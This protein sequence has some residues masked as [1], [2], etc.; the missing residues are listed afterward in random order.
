MVMRET[1]QAIDEAAAEWATR[2]EAAHLP[3]EVQTELDL[4]L[5]GD[6]RR[7]GAFARARAVIAQVRRAKALGP[8]VLSGQLE[9]DAVPAL[10]AA[11]LGTGLRRRQLLI[12]GS[13]AVAASIA[14]AWM[15]SGG[16]SLN[17]ATARG[18]VRLIPLSDGSSVTLNTLSRIAVSFD[19]ARRVIRLLEGEALFN[20]VHDAARPFVI[21]AGA[22]TIVALAS[23]FLV[24]RSAESVKVLVKD[25]QVAIRRSE[26]G[27]ETVLRAG[28][29]SRTDVSQGT[30]L[31]ARPVQPLEVTRALVWREGML[32]FEDMPLNQ[33]VGQFARY[34]D[35]RI[36]LDDPRLDDETVTGL[37]S[38]NDPEGFARAVASTFDLRLRRDG[39]QI[40]LGRKNSLNP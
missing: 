31:Q 37:F 10:G 21:E 27:R 22:A 5:A 9:T 14:V 16:R 25:G 26:R 12:L 11:N 18:E 24:S 33:A 4:W 2:A 23:Q 19:N 38:A 32:S 30:P 28:A 29:N 15:A 35:L 7:L 20:V 8:A 13:A 34:S 6:S 3:A 39:M 1:S 17:Y 40:R 36:V